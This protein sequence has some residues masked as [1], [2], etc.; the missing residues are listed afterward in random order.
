MKYSIQPLHG[1]LALVLL[2]LMSGCASSLDAQHP[3]GQGWRIGK[4]EALGDKSGLIIHTDCRE[5]L[6][7]EWPHP[8]V[9]VV[10]YSYGG[11]PTLRQNRL[12][13]VPA[14]TSLMPGDAVYIK[15]DDCSVPLE[16]MRQ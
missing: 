15:L 9:A 2:L 16:K 11:S 6:G 7:R 13:G 4:V 5:R 8:Q 12:V 1:L 14:Q 3:W 10:S